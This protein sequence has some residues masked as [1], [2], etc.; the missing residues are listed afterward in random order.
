MDLVVFKWQN[1]IRINY[2]LQYETACFAK[3]IFDSDDASII[4]TT[5]RMEGIVTQL[6][7]I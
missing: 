3:F 1:T 7:K 2:T 5:D 4:L 6:K